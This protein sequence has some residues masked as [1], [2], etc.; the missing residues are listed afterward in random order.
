M[1]N[2][3]DIELLLAYFKKMQ[4][5]T[6]V[7]KLAISKIVPLTKVTIVKKNQILAIKQYKLYN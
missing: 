6:K 7:T 5:T 4:N 1:K 3:N 2:N